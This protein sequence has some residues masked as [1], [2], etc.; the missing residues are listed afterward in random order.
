[1]LD[2]RNRGWN[3]PTLLSHDEEP[4]GPDGN[5]IQALIR[6]RLDLGHPPGRIAMD[7]ERLQPGLGRALL[8]ARLGWV[9]STEH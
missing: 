6:S 7:I 3:L 4:S 1:M 5:P 8:R 9:A 2:E